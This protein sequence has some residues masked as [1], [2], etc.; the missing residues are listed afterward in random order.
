M[1]K[2]DSSRICLLWKK[3]LDAFLMRLRDACTRCEGDFVTSAARTMSAEEKATGE[4]ERGKRIAC[5]RRCEDEG[6]RADELRED[7]VEVVKVHARDG[8]VSDPEVGALVLQH[9]GQRRR[10]HIGREEREGATK[11]VGAVG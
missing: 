9:G 2:E 6:L 8:L 10:R 3:R 4:V 1:R 7:V 5:F 11:V